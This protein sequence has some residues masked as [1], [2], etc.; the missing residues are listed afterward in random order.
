[1]IYFFRIGRID[2]RG[3]THKR[4]S[5]ETKR[6]ILFK[7]SALANIV[8][9][10]DN[11]CDRVCFGPLTKSFETVDFV[12]N[13]VNCEIACAEQLQRMSLISHGPIGSPSHPLGPADNICPL[14]SHNDVIEKV[15]MSVVPKPPEAC[16]FFL[17]G[18]CRSG[19]KCPF[20][21]P[22]NAGGSGSKK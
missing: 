6:Q 11:P 10:Y 8:K 16:K 14:L 13:K 2:G 9:E 20:K 4:K 19:S 1:M 22:T 21:H 7:I 5:I 18:R 17:Q 12:D 15:L 3:S